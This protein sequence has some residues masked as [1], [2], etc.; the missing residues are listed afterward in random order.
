MTDQFEIAVGRENN[1][2]VLRIGR[3][4]TNVAGNATVD[5]M[6]VVPLDIQNAMDIAEAMAGKAFE[7]E[8]LVP[9]AGDALKVELAAKHAKKLVPKVVLML[10]SLHGKKL[11]YQAESIVGE[12]LTEVLG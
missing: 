11:Q 10:R 12:C 9:K 8:G 3:V 4:Y 6:A 5:V 2:V 7:C 1:Q